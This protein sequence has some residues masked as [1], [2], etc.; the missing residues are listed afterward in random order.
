MRFTIKTDSNGLIYP[1]SS[2]FALANWVQKV[3]SFAFSYA[4]LR[5]SNKYL[6][7]VPRFIQVLIFLA[8]STLTLLYDTVT[9]ES[10]RFN[11]RLITESFIE[12]YFLKKQWFFEGIHSP[13]QKQSPFKLLFVWAKDL[14]VQEFVSESQRFF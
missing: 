5:F 10:L 3:V 2:E 7:I 1:Y 11:H 4:L 8:Y 12:T 9:I 14:N 13:S 6:K